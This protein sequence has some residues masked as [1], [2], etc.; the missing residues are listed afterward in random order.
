M[1]KIKRV[2]TY[3][4]FGGAFGVALVALTLANLTTPSSALAVFFSQWT[5]DTQASTEVRMYQQLSCEDIEYDIAAV[6]MVLSGGSFAD[7]K[8]VGLTIGTVTGTGSWDKQ[9]KRELGK[10]NSLRLD[11]TEPS[12]FTFTFTPPVSKNTLC[13]SVDDVAYLSIERADLDAPHP[14]V[15]GSKNPNAYRSALYGCVLD[16]GSPCLGDL[17]D[18]AFTLRTVPNRPP[19]ITPLSDQVVDELDTLTFTL[20]ATDPDG[21]LVRWGSSNLP[22]GAELNEMTGAFSWTPTRDQIKQYEI[23]FIVTDDGGP[24]EESSSVIVSI[25]VRDVVTTPDMNQSLLENIRT[26]ELPKNVENSYSA[27]LRNL[28]SFLEGEQYISAQN[29]L[30]ALRGKVTQDLEKGD[31]STDQFNKIIEEIDALLATLQQ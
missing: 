26:Y 20:E 11:T 9:K 28:E 21:D 5:A 23:T 15:Y 2:P 30:Q 4:F 8:H 29:Q 16:N 7:P 1:K 13:K 3:V 17:A 22:D 25:T 12:A 6:D 19:V 24:V 27:H 14:L 10:S 31:I 18:M